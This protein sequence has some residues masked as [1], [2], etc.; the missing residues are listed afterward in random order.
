MGKVTAIHIKKDVSRNRL[1]P[2]Y[3]MT[4]SCIPLSSCRWYGSGLAVSPPHMTYELDGVTA[5]VVLFVMLAMLTKHERRLK[6]WLLR[7]PR[8]RRKA[9]RRPVLL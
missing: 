4:D 2:S 5:T 3:N 7:R 1:P 9:L 8:S 6:Q